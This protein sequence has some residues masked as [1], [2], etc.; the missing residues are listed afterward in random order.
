MRKYWAM[1]TFMDWATIFNSQNVIGIDQEGIDQDYTLYT[2]AKINHLITSNVGVTEYIDRVF[3]DFCKWMQIGDL[4]IIGTGQV[5]QFSV[6][7]IARVSGVYRF[8]QSNTPRHLRDVDI[9]RVLPNPKPMQRFS[10][11]SR[12]E[13]IDEGDFYEAIISML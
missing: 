7:A 5:A 1:K 12:L 13:L 4:I 11:T 3:R 6:S 10:R 2:D 8:N 9:L